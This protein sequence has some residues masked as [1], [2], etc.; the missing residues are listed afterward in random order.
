MLFAAVEQSDLLVVGS[1]V[2]KASYTGLFKHFFD[3]LDPL[4]IAGKPVVL[5]ATGGSH[6][7]ALVLEHHLRPLF[8][9]FRAQTLPTA[10]YAVEGDF[11]NGVLVNE[12][13]KDRI[14]RAVTEAVRTLDGAAMSNNGGVF[15]TKI[16]K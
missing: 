15:A 12:G 3:L 14:G 16:A 2:F 8:G 11:D 4:A 5:T 1:P 9:F 6:H 13:V 7:H 10:V